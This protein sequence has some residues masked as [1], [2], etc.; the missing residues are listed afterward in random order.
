MDQ[1]ARRS[2][3]E[4]RDAATATLFSGGPILTMDPVGTVADALVV[5]GDRIAAVGD[6]QLLARYPEA[7]KVDLG[8]R[9]LLPGFVDAH[10]HLCIAAL[11]PRWADLRGVTDVDRLRSALVAQAAAEPDAEW[12]RGVGWSDL[13][14]GFVPTRHD[15]DALGLDR[16][17]IVVHYSYHQCVVSSAGLDALGISDATPEPP[18]GSFGRSSTGSLDGLLV[19]RAFSAAHATSM[20]PYRDPDRWADHIVEAARALL[21]DGVTCVHDAACP[22][23]AEKVYGRLAQERRLP[24]SVLVMPHAEALL[25]PL[26]R[27]RLDGPA[28]GEGNEWLRTGAVKLFADG[29]VLPAI[30]GRFHGHDLSIGLVFADLDDQVTEVIARGFRVAVHAIGNGGVEAALGA[31]E[32]AARANGD[33]DHRFRVEHASLLSPGQTGRMADVGAVAVVQPGFVHHMGGAVDGFE[34]D[35]ATWMPFAELLEAEVP[36]AGSSD[37]PCA[38]DEPLLTSARGVTRLTSKGT[39]IGPGQSVPYEAWLR[40]YTAGAAHAGC[41]ESERGRLAPGLRADLVVLDGVLDA[42]NPPSVAETWVAGVR[43]YR[44]DQAPLVEKGSV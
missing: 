40:A 7:A 8:G 34:L 27:S 20:A 17:V 31:F 14:A 44:A 2:R 5:E 28:T 16:P 19:E 9:S 39:V 29:G 24:I 33:G 43:V 11:H 36:I 21:A 26:D 13:D 32:A 4:D 41:Q 22:P 35:D 1:A 38:F 25:S 18:G 6:R 15:L 3:F 42:E 30:R 23:S 37:S 10:A 12:I